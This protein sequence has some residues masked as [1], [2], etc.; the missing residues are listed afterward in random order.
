MDKLLF[1]FGLE[2]DGI[3]SN[4]EGE[5][6]YKIDVPSNRHDFQSA[7]GLAQALLVFQQKLNTPKFQSI[8]DRD[9]YYITVEP[10]VNSPLHRI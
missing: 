6:V 4:E 8:S 10:Q 3:E 1:D 2:L 7:E 5:L 9:D